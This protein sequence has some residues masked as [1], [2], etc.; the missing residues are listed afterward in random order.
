MPAEVILPPHGKLKRKH[1]DSMFPCLYCRKPTHRATLAIFGS[2][3]V[4][5][6]EKY[7]KEPQR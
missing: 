6:Y 2:R 7:K 4:E 1:V 3:C 5:C